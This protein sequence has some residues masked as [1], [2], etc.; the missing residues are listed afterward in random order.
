MTGASDTSIP[1]PLARPSIFLSYA[2]EDRAATRQLGAALTAAG[3]EV[4]YDENELG[5]GDAWDQK[6]RRQIRECTYF[7]PVIS[8]TTE[9]RREGYFR[10]EWRLATE[11]SLDMADDV[12]FLVPVV[13]DDT[14]ET[15]AR[16]PEKFLTVQWLRLPGGQPTPAFTTLARRLLAHDHA[17]P[18]PAR[19]VPPLAPPRVPRP[20]TTPPQAAAQPEHTDPPPMPPFPHRTVDDRNKLKYLAE[21]FWWVF[22][23]AWL[24]FKRLPKAIRVLLVLWFAFAF[25]FKCNRNDP[26]EVKKNKDRAAHIEAGDAKALQDAAA[27]LEKTAN[28]KDTSKLGAGFARAGAE[29]ARA[30]SAEMKGA[31]ASAVLGMISFSAGVSD[32]AESKFAGQ[33]FETA[34]GQLSLARPDL[35]KP[36]PADK[37]AADD[38]ALRTLAAAA[39]DD[40]F[41]TA[42]VTDSAEGR[43][44]VV[45]LLPAKAAAP[46][47]TGRY[48]VAAGDVPG[49]AS[50]ITQGVLAALPKP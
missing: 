19:S 32:P 20:A 13:I 24:I 15:G 41:V 40:Y 44:L 21:V 11:R 43:V 22:T 47:W 8:A 16:V 23:A 34:F 3:L 26:D 30:V 27:S 29:I 10:R 35:V 50:A 7:M 28:D 25:V 2:S 48:A 14:A 45:R 37:T 17:E 38:D 36:L 9:R 4:W 1:P 12:M 46:L 39:A 42:Q 6:I 18:S 5:G 49:T 31:P 33:V